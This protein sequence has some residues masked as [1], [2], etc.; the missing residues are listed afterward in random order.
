MSPTLQSTSGFGFDHITV[1]SMSFCIWQ[2]KFF[3][4]WANW[5]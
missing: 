5:A 2:P 4:I 3:Q 1:I